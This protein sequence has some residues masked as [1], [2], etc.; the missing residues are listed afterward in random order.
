M[1]VQTAVIKSHL[2]HI[3]TH[4]DKISLYLPHYISSSSGSGE[5]NLTQGHTAIAD[6]RSNRICQMK[7]MCT[8]SNTAQLASTSHR[9]WSLGSQFEYIDYQT[10][11][12]QPLFALKIA[13][14]HGGSG[15]PSWCLGPTGVNI[16]MAPRSVQQL[17]QGSQSWQTDTLTD[18]PCCSICS[19]RPHLASAEKRPNNISI[20]QWGLKMP[21]DW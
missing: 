21:K 10:C 15:P 3:T 2:Q 20:L 9:C 17:L 5:S 1:A 13:P 18:R 4:T 6:K 8:A 16:W 19:N 12:G 7:P 11:L 14:S